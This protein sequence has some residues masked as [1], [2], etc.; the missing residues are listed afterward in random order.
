MGDGREQ[1]AASR[2]ESRV[3]RLLAGRGLDLGPGDAEQSD[4]L[5]AAVVLASAREPYPR[6]TAA[7]RRRLAERLGRP[8]DRPR[9]SRRSALVAS[10]GLAAAG[11]AGFGLDRLLVPREAEGGRPRAEIVPDA[12][13]WVDVAALA[14]LPE[15]RGV[16]V[17]A[18]SVVAFVF[19]QGDQV[20]AVSAICTHLACTLDWRQEAGVL[21]CPCHGQTFNRDGHSRSHYPLPSLSTVRVRVVGSRVLVLGT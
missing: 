6:P 20:R 1:R 15:G 12:G 13:R 4:A 8:I 18:G 19:R 9:V 10:L 16:R 21:V 14:D 17:A 2:L 7:F 11:L 5:R 3:R